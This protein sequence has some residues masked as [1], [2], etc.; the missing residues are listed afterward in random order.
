[1]S[2]ENNA[3]RQSSRESL[4]KKKKNEEEDLKIKKS[5]IHRE[6]DIIHV[7]CISRRLGKYREVVIYIDIYI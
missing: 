4:K 2:S 6:E 7:M 5:A 1:M 3:E